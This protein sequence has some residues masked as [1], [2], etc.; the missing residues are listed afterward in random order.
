[1]HNKTMSYTHKR[2]LEL[3]RRNVTAHIKICA[4]RF[5]NSP[6][7]EI[8]PLEETQ[9]QFKELVTLDLSKGPLVQVIGDITQKT[10]FDSE[11]FDSIICTEVLEHTSNPFKA[12]EE[13]HRILKPGGE[14]YGSTPLNFRIHNPQPDNWRFT[15]S[16]LKELFKEFENIFITPHESYVWLFPYHY[17]WVAFKKER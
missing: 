4:E 3:I 16:G 13:M 1:M 5:S 6:V 2:Y 8:G 11:S 17:T 15:E 14:I 12:V 9:S 10:E 7:L